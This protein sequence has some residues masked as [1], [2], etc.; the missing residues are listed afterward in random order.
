MDIFRQ[1]TTRVTLVVPLRI[2]L[3]LL[4]V[5]LLLVSLLLVLL[6]LEL[7]LLVLRLLVLLLLVLLVLVLF[8]P[9]RRHRPLLGVLLLQMGVTFCC[10]RY[11][12]VLPSMHL[13]KLRKA[14]LPRPL[15]ADLGSPFRREPPRPSQYSFPPEIATAASPSYGDKTYEA[16]SI[17]RPASATPVPAAA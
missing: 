8:L 12:I 9:G 3:G 2:P 17:L 10:C 13:R 15:L 4:L 5:L 16:R 14:P 7:L 6:L 11:L 1:H